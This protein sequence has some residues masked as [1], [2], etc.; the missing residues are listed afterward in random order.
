MLTWLEPAAGVLLIAIVLHFI[1][2]AATGRRRG[3]P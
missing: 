3:G 1:V 2:T